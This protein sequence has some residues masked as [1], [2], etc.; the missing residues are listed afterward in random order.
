[1][2][3]TLS[4]GTRS[5]SWRLACLLA[6]TLTAC[7]GGGGGA[8]PASNPGSGSG[9]GTNPGT[10]SGGGGAT[11]AGYMQGTLIQDLYQ[12]GL[13]FDEAYYDLA[14]GAQHDLPRS[15]Q[16]V[17]TGLYDQWYANQSTGSTSDL[18]RVDHYDNVAFFDRHSLAQTGGF[19]LTNVANTNQPQFWGP[20]RPSPDGKY[21]LAYWIPNYQTQTLMLSVFDRQGNVIQSGSPIAY[22][23]KSF[24]IAADWLPDGRYIFAAG[25]NFVIATPGDVKDFTVTPLSLPQ[26]TTGPVELSVS[27]DGGHIAVALSQAYANSQ[28]QDVQDNVLFVTDLQGQSFREL[29]TVSQNAAAS[30][31][32]HSIGHSNAIWSP[33]GNYIAFT[34]VYSQ[35][36]QGAPPPGCQPFLVVPSNGQMVSI[37]GISDPDSM[38]FSVKGVSGSPIEANACFRWAAW[39]ATP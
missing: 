5:P 34:V 32:G 30:T 6:L 22:D 1:M 8:A 13:D 35:D 11:T 20:V 7:G 26:G 36:N 27:P 21:L 3:S 2:R 10:G 37:D 18:V 31:I 15:P 4:A 9:S 14:A 29:T 33:D 12:T 16:S 38:K 28:G 23:T 19:S 17:A 25:P 39:I 24:Y